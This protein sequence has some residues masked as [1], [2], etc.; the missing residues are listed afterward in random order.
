MV[1]KA[2]NRFSCPGCEKNNF[3]S[4]NSVKTHFLS[5]RHTF[6][7]P[8]CQNPFK[9]EM[10]LIQHYQK[11]NKSTSP[12]IRNYVPRVLSPII[13]SSSTALIPVMQSRA[14]QTDY[15][16]K[17][18]ELFKQ[19]LELPYGQALNQAIPLAYIPVINSENGPTLEAPQHVTP[20][21]TLYQV[22]HPSEY[23]LILRYLRSRCHSRARLQTEGYMPNLEY[24]E[25]KKLPWKGSIRRDDFRARPRS[26]FQA[27]GSV[28]AIAIDCEMVGVRHGR[29]TLAFL[30]AI[31][32]LT[33]KV[34]IS[35][36]VNPEEKVIDWRFKFSGVTQ[37]IMSAAVQSGAALESWREARNKLW[38]FM[39]DSTVLVGHSLN[40]D[41][42]VLGIS[43]ANVVD[44]SVL[45]A[46]TVFPSII[47]TKTFP[48]HWALKTIAKDL[49]SL[50]IQNGECGHIALEDAFAARDVVIWCIR[51][52]EELKSWSEISR[53]QEEQKLTQKRQRHGK[54]KVKG[55]LPVSNSTQNWKYDT[56]QDYH[57]EDIRLSDYAEELG[58]PEGYDP[59]IV[60]NY[61]DARN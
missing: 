30:S 9:D 19:G 10:S 57:P 55:K 27:A 56:G 17:A 31:D 28:C 22:I 23:N 15:Q 51:N 40:Y 46:E 54:G 47:S 13:P 60:R 61:F 43:H 32:F 36:F 20:G 14:V 29:Q 48:R 7:C 24:V 41:L 35:Q 12:G 44:S 11:Y 25:N 6:Q 59:W 52:P 38:K 53:L 33:G 5:Q 3:R 8:V 2:S 49:L 16:N 50:A 1:Q 45:I 18:L 58:W 26:G 21:A 4:L 39:D 37:E 42:E 34:L